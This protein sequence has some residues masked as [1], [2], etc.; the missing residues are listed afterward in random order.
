MTVLP[1]IQKNI[2]SKE[3]YSEVLYF[4]LLCVLRSACL[5][6]E[7]PAETLGF[8]VWMDLRQRTE[9]AGQQAGADTD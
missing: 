3:I 1:G 2:V 8:K 7:F 4:S 5:A 6:V 9:S